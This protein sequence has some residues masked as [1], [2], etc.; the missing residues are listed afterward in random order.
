M[1]DETINIFDAISGAVPEAAPI[2]VGGILGGLAIWGI[3]YQQKTDRS[4]YLQINDQSKRITLGAL[5]SAIIGFLSGSFLG[6]TVSNKG[7]DNNSAAFV[8]F[9]TGVVSPWVV[10]KLLN[11]SYDIVCKIAQSKWFT[12]VTP[13]QIQIIGDPS[14]K[15]QAGSHSPYNGQIQSGDAQTWGV[16]R[17]IM[18]A[19]MAT[20]NKEGRLSNDELK[21]FHSSLPTAYDVEEMQSQ[22]LVLQQRTTELTIGQ[23]LDLNKLVYQQGIHMDKQ[24]QVMEKQQA[25]LERHETRY[26]PTGRI[27]RDVTFGVSG[28]VLRW[29]IGWIGG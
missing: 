14:S 22:A 8:A 11:H 21:Y 19:Q 3:W 5:Y 9:I 4:K 15:V 16:N 6:I 20:M 26:E 17:A 2:L 7:L 12:T 1:E 18:L 10:H 25:L 29:I 24:E 23:S 28:F 27:I 13:Q